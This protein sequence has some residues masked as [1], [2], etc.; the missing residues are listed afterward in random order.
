[1]ASKFK[2]FNL[3]ARESDFRFSP[4]SVRRPAPGGNREERAGV[5]R[6]IPG[7][8]ADQKLCLVVWGF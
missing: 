3:T 8:E 2:Y 1:L 6:F 5:G 7:K 4:V